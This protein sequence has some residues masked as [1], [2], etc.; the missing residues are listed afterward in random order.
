MAFAIAVSMLVSFSLTPM[1]ASRWLEAHD[2]GRPSRFGERLVDGFYR[3]IER[4]YGAVLRFVMRHRW[5]V[6]VACAATLGSCVPLAQQGEQGLLA[7]QRRGAV[8]GPGARSGGHEPRRDAPHRPSASRAQMRDYPERE[9]DGDDR[10]ATTRRKTH[11]LATIYVRL[12]D[13]GTA[14]GVAER[15][16]GPDAPGGRREAAAGSAHHGRRGAAVR[17]RRL[18]ERAHAVHGPRAGPGEARGD[19]E[20]RDRR[21]CG[22]CPARSTSTRRSSWASPRSASTS[23][24]RAR[25]T[26]ACSRAT[27]RTRCACSSRASRS[28]TTRSAARSTRSTC[29]RRRSTAPTRRGCACSR[30]RR[31]ASG[32][33]R[34]PTS[35]SS[36]R[37]RG[38]RASI[39]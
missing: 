19:R 11:N 7:G 9:A 20:G 8:P 21:S 16:D 6:V 24:A 34:S 5:I 39:D 27:S 36:G 25:P 30:C 35:C 15:A 38:R 3:P 4:V 1:M 18:L 29:A 37:R 28:R 32:S 2:G 31:R 12:T 10:R 22:R 23:I 33:S 13:P 26:S 14:R 17:R